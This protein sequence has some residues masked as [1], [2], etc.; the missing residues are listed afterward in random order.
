[1]N[2]IYFKDFKTEFKDDGATEH[3]TCSFI[4][5]DPTKNMVMADASDKRTDRDDVRLHRF[6][7]DELPNVSVVGHLT[8]RDYETYHMEIFLTMLRTPLFLSTRYVCTFH[9]TD[10]KS[11]EPTIVD[12]TTQ[13]V[14]MDGRYQY[15]RNKSG[16]ARYGLS[17]V[18]FNMTMWMTSAENEK[19]S[20]L[21]ID[22]FRRSIDEKEA[23]TV[24]E[25][26][27]ASTVSEAT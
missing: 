13:T 4:V 12:R 22:A 20:G 23:T 6:E 16:A 21:I 3:I 18:H 5:V 10:S 11:L 25:A 14:V 8:Q 24:S 17:T 27:C 1:M 19:W 2:T 9:T 15:T 26:T 7:V